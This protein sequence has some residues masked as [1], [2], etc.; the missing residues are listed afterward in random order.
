MQISSTNLKA[1]FFRIQR[2]SRKLDERP[3]KVDALGST[4]RAAIANIK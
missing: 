3:Y 4:F 2:C 1:R